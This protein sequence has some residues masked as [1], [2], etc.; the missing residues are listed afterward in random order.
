MAQTLEQKRLRAEGKKKCPRC[1]QVKEL[2]E[3]YNGTGLCIPCHATYQA[4]WR[5]QDGYDERR[6]KYLRKRKYGLTEERY[7]ELLAEQGGKCAICRSDEPGGRWGTFHVDHD[8]ACCPES[9]TCGKC[10]RGLLCRHCNNGLGH[11]QD[12]PERLMAAAAYLIQTQD[13]LGSTSL[14]EQFRCPT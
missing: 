2:S 1:E 12:A 8:H 14:K 3:Y 9:E 6:R 4:E 5:A 7:K 10:V 13:V 11:F